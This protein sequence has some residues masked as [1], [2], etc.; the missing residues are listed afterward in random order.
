MKLMDGWMQVNFYN[1]FMKIGDLMKIS[2]KS[3][4]N[5]VYDVL[6]LIDFS[7]NQMKKDNNE[8]YVTEKGRDTKNNMP[9]ENS[10]TNRLVKYM[11]KNKAKFN[12]ELLGFEVESASDFAENYA[13]VGFIDI[14]V[15]NI[16]TLFTKFNDENVYF[17]FECK[18]INLENRKINN[19]IEHGINRFKYGKYSKNLTTAGMIAYCENSNISVI[20]EHVNNKMNNERLY[21]NEILNLKNS[22]YYI[23]THNRKD[24]DAITIHHLFLNFSKM[25]KI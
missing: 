12:L 23:S 18:R 5:L 10:I 7:Y 3:M 19:Y 21:K 24:S 14:K 13:T 1:Y 8:F 16:S 22:Y 17:A 15:T 9:L 4:N 2:D 25:I 11:R 20:I 6:K